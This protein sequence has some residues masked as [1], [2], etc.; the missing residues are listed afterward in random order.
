ME[1]KKGGLKKKR[2][3]SP[4]FFLVKIKIWESIIGFPSREKRLRNPTQIHYLSFLKADYFD[5]M[6]YCS[7]VLWES[8]WRDY[9][10]A[11]Q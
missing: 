1:K 8:P 4:L 2:C 11:C 6:F 10:T 9:Y 7:R 3:W 5:V